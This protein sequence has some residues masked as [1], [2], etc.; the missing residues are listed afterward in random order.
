MK[1]LVFA[2]LLATAG[3]GLF[4]CNNGAYDADPKT[5][6]SPLNP[7]DPNS[8]VT[9]PL[10][11]MRVAQNGTIQNFYPAYYQ[12]DEEGFLNFSMIRENDREYYPTLR[13]TLFDIKTLKEFGAGGGI[14]TYVDSSKHSVDSVI[15]YGTQPGVGGMKI[16][17]NGN[18]EGNY[19]GTF[20][21]TFYRLLP[22]KD[23]KDSIVF[24][25]GEFYI[26]K[27]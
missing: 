10:G 1:K 14:Y 22:T 13:F 24:A 9:V 25:N 5:T 7:L 21:G 26:P 27:R 23:M 11:S 6:G 3:V 17:L 16:T 19:R 2:A 12:T 20:S 15:T 8:G 4:S 18:E